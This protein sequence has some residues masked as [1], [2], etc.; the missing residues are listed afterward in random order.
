MKLQIFFAVL[1]ISSVFAVEKCEDRFQVRVNGVCKRVPCRADAQC[2]QFAGFCTAANIGKPFCR[3]GSCGCNGQHG[4]KLPESCN[5]NL[6][7]NDKCKPGEVCTPG[8]NCVPDPKCS[9]HGE[10]CE[11]GKRSCCGGNGHCH[12]RAFSSTYSCVYNAFA[13]EDC[14]SGIPCEGTSQC[15]NG[16]CTLEVGSSCDKDENGCPSGTSC[17][18]VPLSEGVNKMCMP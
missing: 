15:R 11:P 2:K 17:R 1:A 5:R 7:G 6:N 12:K 14:S 3:I 18:H 13:N 4:P 8:G 9:F 16:K 10:S